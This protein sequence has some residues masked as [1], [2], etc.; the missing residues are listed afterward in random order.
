[1]KAK[2]LPTW[3]KKLP[4]NVTIC[5]KRWRIKYNM[6]GGCMFEY[7]KSLITVGCYSGSDTAV[8]GLVHEIS[9]VVHVELRYRYAR[10]SGGENGDMLFCLNHNQFE[11]HNLNM[12][13]ALRDC[14]LLRS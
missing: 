5:G 13:A 6:L 14:G 11:N 2:K 10:T 12:V 8:E 9:E 1:M 7:R 3:T 4:K